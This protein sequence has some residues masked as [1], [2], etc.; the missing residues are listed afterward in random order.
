VDGKISKLLN[1]NKRL[2]KEKKERRM[3][4]PRK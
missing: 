4:N 2:E 1:E 3:K